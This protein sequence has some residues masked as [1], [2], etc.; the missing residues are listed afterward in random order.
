MRLRL[1]VLKP[2]EQ[3]EDVVSPTAMV[4]YLPWLAG[5]RVLIASADPVAGTVEVEL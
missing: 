4:V 1:R 3:T 5:V 2:I